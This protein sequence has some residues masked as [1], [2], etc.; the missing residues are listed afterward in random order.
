MSNIGGVTLPSITPGSTV[1]VTIDNTVPHHQA[2][3]TAGQ[4][5]TVNISG[6]PLDGQ[7]LTLIITNDG[8][9]PRTI[10]LGTGFSGNGTIIGVTSKRSTL[11]FEAS[12]GTF[13]ETSRVV[14]VLT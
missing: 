1:T 4:N 11:T 9:L 10:T 3:W 7:T 6:T 2:A 12:G 5:E 8:V 14:G 13:Y